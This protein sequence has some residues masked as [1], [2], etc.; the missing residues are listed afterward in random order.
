MDDHL[1]LLCEA[2]NSESILVIFKTI[3]NAGMDL[4]SESVDRESYVLVV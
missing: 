3:G 1:D 2:V 4:L